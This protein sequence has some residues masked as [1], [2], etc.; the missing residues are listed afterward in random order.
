MTIIVT[1]SR[2]LIGRELT[3]YLAGKY[4]VVEADL[5]LGDDLENPGFVKEFFRDT[6]ADALVNLFALND[7]VG[8]KV[9]RTLTEYLRVNVIALHTVCHEYIVNNKKG[10]I[11][12]F[13]S[14]YGLRSP[15]PGLYDTEKDIGY[16]VSKA[17]VIQ[18]SRHLA[19]HYAPD[20]RV[21]CIAPGGVEHLQDERF[22]SAY[23]AN[24]PM[25][26]MMRVDELNG[27]VDYLCSDASSYVTGTV[28]RVDGGWT[29]W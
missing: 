25:G 17:A 7:H 8:Q 4:P 23:T 24:T 27:M 14:I 26:R 20:I 19:V 22:K 3:H 5:V 15:R 21:N 12:N 9:P 16:G 28:L 6:P 11:V 13:T 29:A 18:L 10:S 1:G 2:G